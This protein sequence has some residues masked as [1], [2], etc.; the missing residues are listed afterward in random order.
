[1]K[2]IEFSKRFPDEASCEEYL[3]NH[4]EKVGDIFLSIFY[5]ILLICIFN[6]KILSLIRQMIKIRLSLVH[7][8]LNFRADYRGTVQLS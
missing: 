8:F 3:K 6:P 4:R 5:T 7:T 1:M 2:L